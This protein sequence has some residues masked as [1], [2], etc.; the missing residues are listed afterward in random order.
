M[1]QARDQLIVALDL[2]SIDA[3]TKIVETLGDSVSTY[4]IGHQLFTSEGPKVISFLK[5]I[6][7]KV[8]L[9]LKLHEIPNSVA[10]AVRIAGH[11]GVDF[12]TVHAS[13]G[14]RM[15]AAAAEAAHDF[16]EMNIIALTVVTG[17]EDED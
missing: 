13:G 17:L 4:K 5:N 12:V 2:D 9:D 7:K 15:L 11:H 10:S 14:R 16:P 3:M 8:F 6:G 1:V